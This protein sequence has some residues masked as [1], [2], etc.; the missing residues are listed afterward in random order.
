MESLCIHGEL[1]ARP[2]EIIHQPSFAYQHFCLYLTSPQEY[3]DKALAFVWQKLQSLEVVLVW[4]R[5]PENIL[6]ISVCLVVLTWL[7]L[8]LIR[9]SG[10][11]PFTLKIRDSRK[12]HRWQPAEYV[13]KPTYCNSCN[14]LCV[15]GSCCESC[16]LCICTRPQCLK[17]ASTAQS[18]KPLSTSGSGQEMTHFWVKG[19]LPIFSLCFRYTQNLARSA[20]AKA[21]FSSL[22]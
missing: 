3:F 8:R 7:V 10:R 22:N 18:C 21:N 19:N 4:A 13:D 1:T 12:A 5:Q 20:T 15:S 2:D 16:G 11:K 14:E 6:I 9:S 17:M